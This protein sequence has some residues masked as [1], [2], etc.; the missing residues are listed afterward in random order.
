MMTANASKTTCQRRKTG[1]FGL[2]S[3][4]QAGWYLESGF[5]QQLSLLDD[6]SLFK[7]ELA[8]PGPFVFRN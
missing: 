3:A 7:G 8:D 2:K 6:V 5:Q 4:M 1:A